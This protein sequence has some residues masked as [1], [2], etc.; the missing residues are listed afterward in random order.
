MSF[1]SAANFRQLVAALK[2]YKKT[3]A[4]VESSCGG[5]INSGILS[6]PGASAVYYGGTVA[7]N[8]RR[9]KPLLLNSSSLHEALVARKSQVSGAAGYIEFKVHWTRETSLA[10]C[11]DLG[12]DYVIAEGGATGPTFPWNDMTCGFAVI[13]VVAATGNP[14]QEFK[15]VRQQVVYSTHANRQGNMTLFTHSAAEIAL[16][17]I[18]KREAGVDGEFGGIL[19]DESVPLF[20]EATNGA[21]ESDEVSPARDRASHLRSQPDLLRELSTSPTSRYATTGKKL[22]SFSQ[23]LSVVSDGIVKRWYG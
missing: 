23:A 5:L 17:V 12:V 2:R 6:Q 16:Q 11:R 13:C 18:L 14:N 20:V 19:S 3:V 7:Y 1:P 21:T 8:T 10:F 9:A 4:V 15:V 22:D